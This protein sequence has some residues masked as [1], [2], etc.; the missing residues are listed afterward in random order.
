MLKSTNFIPK[1]Y[2]VE[3]NPISAEIVKD[4]LRENDVKFESSG[5]Y[6]LVHIEMFIVS[7]EMHDRIDNYLVFLP[8]LHVRQ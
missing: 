8:W 5:C 7:Q 2:S 1:W 3:L 4:F 6:N